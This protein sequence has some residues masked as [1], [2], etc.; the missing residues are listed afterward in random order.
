MDG[1]IT[2]D[3][4]KKPTDKVQYL[5]PSSCH[6]NHIF[7]NIPYSLA[8]RLVRICSTEELLKNRLSEL[9]DMLLSRNYNKNVV[10][11]ALKK[12]IEV[13][14]SD[15]LEKV[16][17]PQTERVILAIT[18]HPS[19]TSVSNTL[20]T[21]WNTMIKDSTLKKVFA[22]PPMLAFRQPPNLRS[23]LVR[24]KVSTKARP[25]RV[26]VGT[27][28]CGKSCKLCSYLNQAKDLRSTVTS[29][30]VK[31]ENDFS[32]NTIGVIYLVTCNKCMKQYIGQTGRKF[33]TRMKEHITDIK[34]K[35]DKVMGIHFNSPGHSLDNFTV[36]VIEKV[37]PNN[38]HMLLER[39][40]FWIMKFETVLP[41]GLNSHV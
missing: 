19:L 27:H 34:K 31:C 35:E 18:Y 32:C 13:K 21:H 12:A 37:C 15:A 9:S 24:A 2:T 10:K 11:A 26:N 8:L 36:Q 5:L 22:K 38:P 7:K 20:L 41:L 30:K 6:P 39:E 33:C 4:Y 17:K 28:P 14:R 23:M 29:E 25:S 1:Q 40:R 3:L 16:M